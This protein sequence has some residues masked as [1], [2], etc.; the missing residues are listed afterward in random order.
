MSSGKTLLCQ[1]LAIIATG[2]P[3]SVSTLPPSFDEQDKRLLSFLLDGQ[4]A[5]LLDNISSRIDSNALCA[6]ITAP[7]YVSRI[8]QK[9]L[10]ARVSTRSLMLANGNNL[11]MTGDVS[12]RFLYIRLGIIRERPQDRAAS[13][14]E[15]PGLENWVCEN[16]IAFILAAQTLVRAYLIEC[17][18]NGGVPQHV[19]ARR[20]AVG[21]RFGSIE[22]L[23]DALLW[24]GEG[25]GFLGFLEASAHDDQLD[26]RI[27]VLRA[28]AEAIAAHNKKAGQA[29][30]A[31]ITAKQM[32][33]QLGDARDL[34]NEVIVPGRPAHSFMT[35]AFS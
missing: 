28:V 1:V 18:K 12:S 21:S 2:A 27:Q 30:A 10:V 25:D 14:F 35:F 20:A 26:E 4:Q 3:V 6:L 13:S 16:R 7:Y 5:I 15:K 11:P 17:R 19:I 22:V 34:L 33:S 29:P 24:C 31:P 8:L 9:S 23:R 32:L